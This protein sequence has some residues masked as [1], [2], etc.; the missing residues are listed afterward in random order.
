MARADSASSICVRALTPSRSRCPDFRTL[1]R[2]GIELPSNFVAT[3]NAELA[4]GV[5]RGDDHRLRRRAAGRRAEHAE[6]GGPAASGAGRGADRTDLRRRERARA[7]RQG[8]RIERR[9][10][11]QRVAAAADR[12]WIGQRRRHHRSRRHQHELLGRRPAEPQRRAV[13][14]SD[15]ADRRPRFRSGHRRR[16]RQPDPARRRQ[17]VQ[18]LDVRRLR[19]PFD[20]EQNLTDGAAS[21]WA[22]APATPSSCC[23]TSA[24]RS[25]DRFERDKLWFFGSFRDVGN[26]NIVANTF[27]PDGSPGI[28]DQTVQNITGRITWQLNAKNKVS[29]Y[30]DR[31]FKSLD[32][33]LAPLT[34]PSLAA[35]GRKPVLYYTGAAKWTS[36]VTSRL[37]LEAGWG[38]SVQS[39]NTGTV[40]ARRPAGA[41]HSGVVRQ[42]VAAGSGH[43]HADDRQRRR[44]QYHRAAVHVDDVGDLRHRVAQH[45]GRVA[46]ALRHQ[47]RGHRIERRPDSALPQRR[48][49]LGDRP[50]RA[51]VCAGGH[52]QPRRRPRPL[53]AGLMALQAADAQSRGPLLLPARVGR[54]RRRAGRPVRAGAAVRRHSRSAQ[55]GRTSRRD[56]AP[57][58]I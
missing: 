43:R 41:R 18:R 35:G 51:A 42:C 5:A 46:V 26:R 4:V 29:V 38:A 45:Q 2:D 37:M 21:R 34:E 25:A 58:T 32:R 31:A 24:P 30:K 44:D 13:A 7:G 56:S 36:P 20:A 9:R 15:R 27:M 54:C 49:G 1:V 48:S 57:P 40:S 8:Q 33:E 50:Q 12:A 22:S 47:Q 10:R 3:V 6:I 53:R 17:P 11:P 19:R 52:A 28:F 23:S 16:P 14:G 39:R 55:T